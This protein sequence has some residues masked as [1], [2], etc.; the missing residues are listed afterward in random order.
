M[1]WRGGARAALAAVALVLEHLFERHAE[2]RGDP[3]CHLERRRIASLFDR[4]DRLPGH[5][6]LLGSVENMGSKPGTGAGVTG[7][8]WFQ[9][10]FQEAEQP[11]HPYG[12]QIV[13]FGSGA[14]RNHWAVG[15]RCVKLP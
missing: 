12:E 14:Y 10:S 5:A 7:D 13:G 8:G 4:H 15:A 9:F 11:S 6:D 2:R 1:W 3:E